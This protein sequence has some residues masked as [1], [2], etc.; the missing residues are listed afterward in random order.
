MQAPSNAEFFLKLS[1]VNRDRFAE[2]MLKV[3]EETIPILFGAFDDAKKFEAT[4]RRFLECVAVLRLHGSKEYLEWVEFNVGQVQSLARNIVDRSWLA[5]GRELVPHLV[6]EEEVEEEFVRR[7][8]MLEPS[9]EGSG[10]SF[11]MQT[12]T[13]QDADVEMHEEPKA[14]NPRPMSGAGDGDG[15]ASKDKS[16]SP[17]EPVT[18]KHRT[19][20]RVTLVG[21]T[22]PPEIVKAAL[23]NDRIASDRLTFINQG[24]T[25][26]FSEDRSGKLT[27]NTCP[28]TMGLRL[29]AA[30]ELDHVEGAC[31]RCWNDNRALICAIKPTERVCF[32]CKDGK[33]GCV[34]SGQSRDARYTDQK[35][36]T[37]SRT[38]AAKEAKKDQDA[39]I[40]PTIKIPPMRSASG[41]DALAVRKLPPLPFVLIETT[42]QTSKSSVRSSRET[43]N[44]PPRADEAPSSSPVS[45]KVATKRGRKGKK[46]DKGKEK[47]TSQSVEDSILGTVLCRYLTT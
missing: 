27:P 4:A 5:W 14:E 24:W 41:V 38:A 36:Q 17:K 32:R 16:P 21:S 31:D 44:L 22:D 37:R 23:S 10:S 9:N 40:I 26:L 34:W 39:P 19:D 1:G 2:R 20:G 7:M 15:I 13:L 11:R 46:L 45:T 28:G 35:K 33:F 12:L 8:G 6:E 29:D 25:M 42:S 43:K 30:V 18:K 47:A 3:G